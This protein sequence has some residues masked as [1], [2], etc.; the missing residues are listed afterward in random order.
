MCTHF[1]KISYTKELKF[2]LF[3]EKNLE[4]SSITVDSCPDEAQDSLSKPDGE[5]EVSLFTQQLLLIY[6]CIK[7]ICGTT[8]VIGT[9]K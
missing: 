9:L 7:F 6:D 2:F 4:L 8:T 3:S 5:S 1:L